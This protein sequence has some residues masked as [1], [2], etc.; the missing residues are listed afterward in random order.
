MHRGGLRSQSEPLP[1]FLAIGPRLNNYRLT[2][3]KEAGKPA[4]VPE[5]RD[6]LFCATDPAYLKPTLTASYFST[7]YYSCSIAYGRPHGTG[8]SISLA[9]DSYTGNFT[10]GFKSGQGTMRYSNG[11]TYTGA[12]ADNEPEGQG[13]MTYAKTGNVYTGGFKKRKRHGKGVMKFQ[14]ADEEQRLC[15]IC[16]EN[17]MDAVFYDCGHVT[18]CETCARQLDDCPVCRRKVKAVVRIWLSA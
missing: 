3:H 18:A 1:T 13:E 4:T 15:Q 2:R 10:A 5:Y 9:G 7:P 14:V 11:D 17:E 6:Y 8:T 12:W 16:Y